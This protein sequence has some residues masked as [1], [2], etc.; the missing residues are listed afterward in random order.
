MLKPIKKWRN[1]ESDSYEI[2]YSQW[3]AINGLQV[4]TGIP[5]NHEIRWVGIKVVRAAPEYDRL[6]FTITALPT[7]H[8]QSHFPPLVTGLQYSDMDALIS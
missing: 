4:M 5:G 1:A 3:R 2:F 8:W 6:D 7:L